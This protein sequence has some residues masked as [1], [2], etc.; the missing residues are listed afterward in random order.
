MIHRNSFIRQNFEQHFLIMIIK[1]KGLIFIYSCFHPS[2]SYIHVTL[3]PWQQKITK[4]WQK[5][6]FLFM[7]YLDLQN[8]LFSNSK[9]GHWS[10]WF[11]SREVNSTQQLHA[12]KCSTLLHIAPCSMIQIWRN[13]QW[14]SN[15]VQ[16]W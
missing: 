8:H 7:G 10:N 4:L 9:E 5:Y 1:G 16:R 14:H 15:S 12:L 13:A 11:T 6:V 2:T 3:S